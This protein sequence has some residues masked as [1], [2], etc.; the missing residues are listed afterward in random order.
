MTC[1]PRHLNAE[2]RAVAEHNDNSE[3]TDGDNE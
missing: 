2:D 3:N 1:P